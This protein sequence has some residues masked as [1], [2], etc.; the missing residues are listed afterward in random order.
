MKCF[1]DLAPDSVR[2]DSNFETESPYLEY[3]IYFQTTGTYKGTFFRIPTLN[4]GE[5]KT[6]R[7]AISFNGGSVGLLRGNSLVASG[8]AWSNGVRNQI[9]KMNIPVTMEVPQEG[10]YSLRVYKSDAGT[11]FDKIVL[12]NTET[13]EKKS[14]LG[15][16]ESY[17]T[18]SEYENPAISVLPEFSADSIPFSL[19]IEQYLYDFSSD[20]NRASSGYTGIDSKTLKS[21]EKG[22]EWDSLTFNNVKAITEQVHKKLPLGIRALFMVADQPPLNSY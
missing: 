16:P 3:K 7:I 15:P 17:N 18:N 21:D 10:W 2:I 5:G 9:E 11:E 12:Y 4:E 1:P 19:E 8:V 6:C 20:A 14:H 22:Y 13:G